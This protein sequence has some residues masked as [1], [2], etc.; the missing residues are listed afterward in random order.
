M[1]NIQKYNVKCVKKM[2]EFRIL[3]VCDFNNELCLIIKV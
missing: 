2:F 1:Q 3:W